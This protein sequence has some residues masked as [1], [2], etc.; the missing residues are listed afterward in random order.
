MVH[1]PEKIPSAPLLFEHHHCWNIQT[2]AYGSQHQLIPRRRSRTM[3]FSHHSHSGQFCGHAVNTLEEVV[4][5]AITKGLEVFCMTEHMPRDHS[6]DLYAEEIAAGTTPAQLDAIFEAYKI[7]ARR[8]QAKYRDQIRI[9]VGLE[10]DWIRPQS[11]NATIQRLLSSHNFDMLVGSVHHVHT[12]PIDF[13][14]ELYDKAA[15]EAAERSGLPATDA[16][17]ALAG[18]YFDLQYD[19]LTTLRPPVVG[20]FDLIRLL[21]HFERH[22]QSL[23]QWPDVWT[24]VKRNLAAVKQ[25]GGCLEINSAGLRKGLREPYPCADICK[26]CMASSA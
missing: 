1:K 13:S 16:E 21:A 22:G 8:L 10:T 19:M 12:I 5:E 2:P 26:V 23:K 17:M 18:D 24:K 20:H 11:C 7:E 9:L 6:E 14:Q 25:Y 3:P 4:Q 15:A